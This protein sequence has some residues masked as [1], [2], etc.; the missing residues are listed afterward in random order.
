MI[1]CPT[2]P[3]GTLMACKICKQPG[4]FWGGL[5]LACTD[6][7]MIVGRLQFLLPL[8]CFL[9]SLII[10]IRAVLSLSH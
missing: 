9:K 4:G 6:C 7:T 2:S 3:W 8:K 5:Y 10:L 1:V